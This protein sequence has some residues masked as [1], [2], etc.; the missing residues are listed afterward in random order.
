[1]PAPTGAEAEIHAVHQKFADAWNRHDVAGL[2]NMWTEKGDYTE[3]DG[4]RVIHVGFEP[5]SVEETPYFGDDSEFL[6]EYR[7]VRSAPS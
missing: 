6:F 5:A 3:P 7:R 4:P 1:M 2:A